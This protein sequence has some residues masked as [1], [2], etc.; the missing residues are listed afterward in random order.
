MVGSDDLSGV[1][2]DGFEVDETGNALSKTVSLGPEPGFW[3][4][5]RVIW[6]SVNVVK[7]ERYC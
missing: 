6:K 5:R 2:S 4:F 3:S 7:S 1:P